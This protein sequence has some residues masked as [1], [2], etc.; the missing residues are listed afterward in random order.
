MPED[1]VTLTEKER[2]L[3][4]QEVFKLANL[5]V[6]E[7]VDK[8]RLTGGEPLVRKDIIDIIGKNEFVLLKIQF[9]PYYL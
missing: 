7:G 1:G 3:S 6:S 4:S 8:I 2:L 5:F 9:F